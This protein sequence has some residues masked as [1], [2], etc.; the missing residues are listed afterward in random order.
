MTLYLQAVGADK[1]IRAGYVTILGP[2]YFLAW[3]RGRATKFETREDAEIAAKRI[4]QTRGNETI[5]HL[6]VRD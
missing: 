1:K 4:R 3:Q 2:S 5:L 6:V